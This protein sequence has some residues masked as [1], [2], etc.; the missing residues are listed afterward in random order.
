MDGHPPRLHN[1]CILQ[2]VRKI[3]K[4][5]SLNF[6]GAAK[7][8]GE[9]FQMRLSTSNKG[10][11]SLQTPPSPLYCTPAHNAHVR[12]LL[13]HFAS[14]NLSPLSRRQRRVPSVMW[15]ATLTAHQW[16]RKRRRRS[17]PLPIVPS[18]IA[19]LKCAGQRTLP[20]LRSVVG[21]SHKALLIAM[22][23]LW[24]SVLCC[25]NSHQ[26]LHLNCQ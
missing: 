23:L 6:D 25:A 11:S 21:H 4:H 7:F 18:I 3:M 1:R 22:V 8:R 20:Q 19:V 26:L 12:P 13:S 5:E 9:I 17:G 2:G 16:V 15:L 10:K 14:L 24:D